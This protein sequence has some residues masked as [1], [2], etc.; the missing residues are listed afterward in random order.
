MES[1]APLR[2][3]ADESL[4]FGVVRALR[5][6]GYDVTAIVELEAGISDPEVAALAQNEERI[7]LTEDKDFGQLVF[8]VGANAQG[9]VL[10]RFS[11]QSRQEMIA[12]VVSAVEQIG[13]RLLGRF[14]VVQPG[15]IRLSGLP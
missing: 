13:P 7:L 14:A 8:A 4:D 12:A 11:G 1:H 2:F 6:A 5:A 15:K 3:L 9:V 10:V